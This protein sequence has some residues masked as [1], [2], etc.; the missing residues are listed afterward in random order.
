[1]VID[2]IQLIEFETFASQWNEYS[3]MQKTQ[4]SACR[5][6]LNL[7]QFDIEIDKLVSVMQNEMEGLYNLQ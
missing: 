3:K 7:L 5:F 6:Q 2:F 1:M 4:R